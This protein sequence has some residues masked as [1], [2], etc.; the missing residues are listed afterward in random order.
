LT[1]TPAWA[2]SPLERDLLAPN[3]VRAG[4]PACLQL[5]LDP[6]A[7]HWQVYRLDQRQVARLDFG[8]ETQQCLDTRGYAPGLYFVQIEVDEAAGGRHSRLFKLLVQP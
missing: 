4:E 8:H 5:S 7:S 3:P 2:R 1:Q 6:A